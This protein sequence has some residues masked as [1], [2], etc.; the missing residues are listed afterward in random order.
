MNAILRRWWGQLLVV[1]LAVSGMELV[2]KL[3]P[4][5]TE[6]TTPLFLSRESLLIG[7][8]LILAAWLV[9]TGPVPASTMGWRRPTW[10]TMAFGLLCLL[11]LVVVSVLAIYVMRS[12][13]LSQSD[14]VLAALGA[15]PIWML[16]LIALT[17]GI[18]EEVL[19]RGVILN[20]L[21]S[22]SGK[23][24]LGALGSLAIFAL[25][26]AGG[27]GWSQVLF[28]AVPGVVLT[29]FF[30]WKRDLGIC[31]IGH[32]LTDLIGLLGAYAQVHHP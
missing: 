32:F 26:H 30:L 8:S 18:S 9:R 16:V 12:W 3:H 24:W 22:A 2:V 28:A 15:K 29:L 7:G 4:M 20:Y 21:A 1:A 11:V 19:F 14:S 31:I 6:A 10:R 23:V 5:L 25:L 27:W 13:G 17:A